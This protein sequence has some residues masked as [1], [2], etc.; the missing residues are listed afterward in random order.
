MKIIMRQCRARTLTIIRRD[1]IIIIHKSSIN[2]IS[3][4][5]ASAPEGEIGEERLGEE[6]QGRPE[7]IMTL[8]NVGPE[9]GEELNPEPVTTGESVVVPSNSSLA[10]CASSSEMLFSS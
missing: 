2:I 7:E 9:V 5:I 4:C 10:S 3:S 8:G 1:Y 6:G